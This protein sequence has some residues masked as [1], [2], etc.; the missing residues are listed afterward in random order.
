GFFLQGE[1]TSLSLEIEILKP[2]PDLMVG[3]SI[4]NSH[5]HPIARS[6]LCDREEYKNI[7]TRSGHYQL[8]FDLD[9]DLFHPG[10]YQIKVDCFLLNQKNF[11]HEDVLLKFAIYSQ[12][13]P[14][15]YELGLE[16][17]GISLGNRWAVR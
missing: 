1:K 12:T 13:K 6:R 10:E 9:L 7:G 11:L 15:K 8:I 5:N 14:L 16:K 3:F 2:H 4:L 17:D